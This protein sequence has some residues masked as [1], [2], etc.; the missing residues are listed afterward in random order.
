[1]MTG[2][3][4]QLLLK[5]G[6]TEYEAKAYLALLKENPV[7]GYILSKNSGI[8]RSRI[9]DVLQSLIVKGLVFKSLDGSSDFYPLDLDLFISRIERESQETLAAF[10]SR[11]DAFLG[12]SADNRS[13]KQITGQDNLFRVARDM[14]AGAKQRISLYIWEPEA[15]VIYPTLLKAHEKGTFIRGIAFGEF[16][17]NPLNLH[18]HRRPQDILSEIRERW[19]IVTKDQNCVLASVISRGPESTGT[20]SNDPGNVLM[21]EDYILHD[22]MLNYLLTEFKGEE[23]A[24]IESKLD[25]LRAWFKL[26]DI[27]MLRG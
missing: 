8:P 14:I 2:D 5:L 16:K 23:R 18:I 17:K 4:V 15:E 12:P 27:D 25:K 11:T 6:L 19:L 24:V 1:M 20:L 21:F 3:I 22:I 26:L 9:Y 13:I 10:K 7:N